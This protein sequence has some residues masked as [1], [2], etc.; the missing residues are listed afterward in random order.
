MYFI[1]GLLTGLFCAFIVRM[2]VV[3]AENHKREYEKLSMTFNELSNY[4]V[5]LIKDYRLALSAGSVINAEELYQELIRVKKEIQRI[6]MIM[7]TKY[8]Y[9]HVRN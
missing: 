8:Y 6:D 1:S 3:K 2:L 5:K 9:T 4:H 7:L